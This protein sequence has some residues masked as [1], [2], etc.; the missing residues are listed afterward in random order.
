MTYNNWI[1]MAWLLVIIG[2]LL[3]AAITIIT[4]LIVKNKKGKKA[5]EE[6]EPEI[7]EDDEISE[8]ETH[9]ETPVEEV[10][11][12]A[13]EA[14]NVAV[15]AA[16]V[17]NGAAESADRANAR[18]DELE[19]QARL[20]ANAEA[21][22]LAEG[23]LAVKNAELASAREMLHFLKDDKGNLVA[24]SNNAELELLKANNS[25][26]NARNKHSMAVN[27]QTVANTK[28]AEVTLAGGDAEALK[29]ATAELDAAN[30]AVSEAFA[31][32]QAAMA[33]VNTA[34]KAKADAAKA[35]E[36]KD[37]EIKAANEKIE[38]LE[39]EIKALEDKLAELKA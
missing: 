23:N 10:C 12:R 38:A 31:D 15:E 26:N 27:A 39:K 30:T 4:I 5:A 29:A 14:M 37:A 13:N 34:E 7:F 28:V 33:A 19:H 20:N 36:A 21:I 25:K 8:E 35:V 2:V 22:R 17:A 6:T 9:E 3:L 18:L 16:G 1:S 32:L 24:V 11:P